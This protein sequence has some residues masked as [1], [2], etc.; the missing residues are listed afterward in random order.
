MARKILYMLRRTNRV[1]AILI[2]MVL[3]LCAGA[4]LLDIVLR[5]LGSSFGGTDEIAGY[6][7]AVVSAWGMGFAMLELAHVRIDVLRSR[8]TPIGR[9]LLDLTAMFALSSTITVIAIY[10]WPVVETSIANSSRAN[11]PLETDLILVQIPWFTGWLWFVA[12]AWLTF[13]AALALVLQGRYAES[14]S[15]I[16]AFAEQEPAP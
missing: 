11:T 4:V 7:M 8:A 1:L 12:M 9:S 10:C 5:R 3:L 13:A 16:G 15:V 14:E 6:V 2:G